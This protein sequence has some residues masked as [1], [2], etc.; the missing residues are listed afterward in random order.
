M[1]YRVCDE[2]SGRKNEQKTIKERC[3]PEGVLER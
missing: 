2:K 3:G 1:R